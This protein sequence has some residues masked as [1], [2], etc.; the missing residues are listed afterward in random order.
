[1]SQ[2]DPSTVDVELVIERI[3]AIRRGELP[4]ESVS[5]E[6]LRAAV[7]AQRM[8]FAAGASVSIDKPAEKKRVSNKTNL[9]VPDL[10]D[11]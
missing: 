1:M 11:L 5:I 7:A 2:I 8:R 10:G 3:Q 6:E 4:A 9:I